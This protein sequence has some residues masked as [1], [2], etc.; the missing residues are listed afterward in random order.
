MKFPPGAVSPGVRAKLRAAQAHKRDQHRDKGDAVDQKSPP[1]PDRRYDQAGDGRTNHSRGIE[2]GRIERHGIVQVRVANQFR[3]ES[4]THRRIER[5]SAAKQKCEDVDMPELDDARHGQQSE[6]DG[7]G[8]HRRLRG[9]HEFALI[10]MVRGEARPWHEQ[11]LRPELQR[12]H[13]TNGGSV[14]RG[15]LGE[16]QP[17]LGRPLHPR[18]DIRDE[19]A[20]R[21]HTIIVA[22]QRPEDARKYDRHERPGV[23]PPWN[24]PNPRD[25]ISA[26][27]RA[28][29]PT[30][31]A[32]LVSRNS[33]SP[34][35]QT[36]T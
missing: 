1:R 21:P 33:N 14:M 30:A 24:R 4:L 34:T 29:K 18:A 10:E 35:R 9:D 6:R 25:E 28:P 12:H 15:E 5:R 20:C 3:Y 13:E 32:S 2:R 16:H 11:K 8:A 36:R 7:E 26:I 23:L 17:V 22:A 27:N 19:A 31:S